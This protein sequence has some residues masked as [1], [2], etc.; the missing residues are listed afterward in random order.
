MQLTLDGVS[1]VTGI[2]DV[3]NQVNGGGLSVTSS[4]VTSATYGNANP[5]SQPTAGRA[6]LT[7]P[8]Q[9]GFQNSVFYITSPQTAYI[10]GATPN[11]PAA[12]GGL[13][14]Q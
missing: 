14:K 7:L 5:P 8:N 11:T 9:I 4:Q 13:L 2:A 6:A 12:D 3:S 10:L 1:K